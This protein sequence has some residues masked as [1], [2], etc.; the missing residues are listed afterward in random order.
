[1]HVPKCPLCYAP[2]EIREV[3][4]C[5]DCGA[6]PAE[7]QHLNRGLH[8]YDEVRAFGETIVLCD[9]CQA[10][11]ANYKPMYFNLPSDVKPGREVAFRRNITNPRVSKDEYCPECARRLAFLEFVSRVRSAKRV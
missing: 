6:D 10:D 5:F 1:M 3:A 7:L 11:F 8:T 9:L 2:L 4:P